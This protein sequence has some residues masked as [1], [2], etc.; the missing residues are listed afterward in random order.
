INTARGDNAL[1]SYNSFFGTNTGTNNS[2]SEILLSPVDVWTTNDTVYAV[3]DSIPVSD[4]SMNLQKGKMVLSASGNFEQALE[5]NISKGDTVKILVNITPSIPQLD[6]M[7]GGHPR[8]IINGVVDMNPDDAL[9]FN[10][11]PRT[12]V[13]INQD[14]SKLYIIVVDGRQVTSAGMTLFELA[15]YMLSI[16]CYN[17]M[18]LDG[19]GSSTMVVRGEIENSPSDGIE[20]DVANALMVISTA[21]AGSVSQL[22]ISPS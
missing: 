4:G 16:G 20:R 5:G 22:K 6:Q 10:R 13:G 1:I 12:A 17:A 9:V 7:I 18:N 2:G 11:H 15:D 8:M 3:V 21:P 19:G 14:T